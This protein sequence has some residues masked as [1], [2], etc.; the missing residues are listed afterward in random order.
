MG[1]KAPATLINLLDNKL[2]SRGLEGVSKV[3]TALRASQYNHLTNDYHKKGLKD[4]W[5]HMPDGRRIQRDLY[6]AFLLQHLNATKTD[7][8][9][10]ALSADYE[11]FVVLHDR[12]IEELKS[13]PKTPAS[14]GLGRR[15]S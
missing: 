12:C 10:N 11:K 14:M 2:K 4:R 15:A 8:D 6:S 1:N 13:A 7:F 3:P 9:K 5:N